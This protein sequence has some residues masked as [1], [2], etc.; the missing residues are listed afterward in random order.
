LWVTIWLICIYPASMLRYF[1]QASQIFLKAV[2]N[3]KVEK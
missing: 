3:Q 1:F 2:L